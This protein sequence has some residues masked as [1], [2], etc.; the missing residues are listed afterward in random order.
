MKKTTL[1]MCF[2]FGINLYGADKAKCEELFRSAIFNFYLENSCKF[3]KH[4]SS[5]I[6][7]EFSNQNCTEMF[8]DDDMKKLNSEVLGDSYQKMKKIGRDK[9]CKNNKVKYDE[10]QTIYLEPSKR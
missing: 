8:S 5:A 7:K 4:I 2:L 10:L 1:V 9:F 3:D 6:R